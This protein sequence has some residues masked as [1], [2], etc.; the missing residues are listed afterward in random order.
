MYDSWIFWSISG[1][2]V[3]V[4]QFIG[5]WSRSISVPFCSIR[6]VYSYSSGWLSIIRRSASLEIGSASPLL[7]LPKRLMLEMF[8]WVWRFLTSFSR[9]RRIFSGSFILV[10]S[11]C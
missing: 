9:G 10:F 2:A 11:L 4:I 3:C 8:S 6:S 1:G 5:M 7:Q